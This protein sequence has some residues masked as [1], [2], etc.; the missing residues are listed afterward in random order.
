MPLRNPAKPEHGSPASPP[1]FGL[2][3]HNRLTDELQRRIRLETLIASISS[4]IA[5]AAFDALGD[6]IQ[7]AL[8]EVARFIGC[9]RALMYRFTADLSAAILASDWQEPAGNTSPALSEIN[10]SVAPEVLDFFLARKTLNSPSPETLP[11]G[12]LQLNELPGVERVQSRISV[13]VV[14]GTEA[15]GILCFHSLNVERH[16]LEE[17]HRLLGLLGEI[18]GSALARAE[19]ASA[20]RH[21]KESAERANRAKSEFLARMSHELRTPLNGMLG[22]A[23]L[24]KNRALPAEAMKNVAAIER[25]GDYLLKLIGDLLDLSRIEADHVE[26]DLCRLNLDE[27]LQELVGVMNIRATAK[28]L[29]FRCEA[30]GPHPQVTADSRKL[31]Q[32]LLNLLDNAIKFTESGFVCL[33]LTVMPV[34]HGWVRLRFD[35]EDSGPGI[36]AEE[37]ERIFEPFHQCRLSGAP[38]PGAGLGLAISRKLAELMGGSLCVSAQPGDGSTFTVEIEVEVADLNMRTAPGNASRISGYRGRRRKALVVDDNADN[39]EIVCELLRSLGFAVTEACDGPQA[40]ASASQN[41]PDVVFMDLVMPGIDGF[42][43]T[44]RIRHATG[45]SPPVIIAVSA[46]VFADT[47][48]A[49]I[50]AGCDAFIDKPLQFGEVMDVLAKHLQLEW[51]YA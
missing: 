19:S 26:L 30:S 33:R 27:F 13:P 44:H 29:A 16:W 3:E 35:V 39:R 23:Q 15:T 31:R 20:L 41:T 46:D 7:D 9:D 25:C 12:F 2:I 32:V 1:T 49:A 4:R 50:D 28:C 42:E 21:A 51:Q 14:Q 48:R 38:V 11:P 17:D 22:H 40:L 18:I 37:A 24:L 10:R 34:R 6:E 43:T 47:R 45:D 5:I 8:G 36:A